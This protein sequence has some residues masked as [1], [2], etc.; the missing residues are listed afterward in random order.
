MSVSSSIIQ[1]QT[2]LM[3]AEFSVSVISIGFTS[4]S[5]LHNRFLK[6]TLDQV[7]MC[8]GISNAAAIAS[9]T[10]SVT[11]EPHMNASIVLV[12]Y[13]VAAER[14]LYLQPRRSSCLRISAR[15]T[16]KFA[17]VIKSRP[18]LCVCRKNLTKC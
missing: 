4:F 18:S 3:L 13:P 10:S 8:L 1:L 11:L 7:A 9:A 17:V 15:N 16:L 14:F 2:P 5:V 12:V 6:R